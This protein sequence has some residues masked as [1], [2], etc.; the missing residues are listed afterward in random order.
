MH[1]IYAQVCV[2]HETKER[3]SEFCEKQTNEQTDVCG[4]TV[5]KH[6]P[7]CNLFIVCILRF[8][9]FSSFID[10]IRG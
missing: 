10:K 6:S 4:N 8:S 3:G 1:S 2:F 9:S 5:H 7:C